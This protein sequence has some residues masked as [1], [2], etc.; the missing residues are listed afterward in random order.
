L[1]ALS[2]EGIE[3]TDPGTADVFFACSS[4]LTL[5]DG[6][7]RRV[8]SVGNGVFSGGPIVALLDGLDGRVRRGP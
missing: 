2:G 3:E 5:S 4:T 1:A 6:A 7:W 8:L